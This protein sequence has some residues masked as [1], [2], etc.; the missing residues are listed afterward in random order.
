MRTGYLLEFIV[1]L[2]V[3][4]FQRLTDLLYT[5]TRSLLLCQFS[6]LDFHHAARRRLANEFGIGAGARRRPVSGLPLA[7][8]PSLRCGLSMG[9]TL[10]IS[11]LPA[12]LTLGSGLPPL[13]V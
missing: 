9:S 13:S 3:I 10:R 11:S 2:G 5:G 12:R 6:K 1:R 4:A 7:D 8:G